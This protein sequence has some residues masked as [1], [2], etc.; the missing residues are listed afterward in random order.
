MTKQM[1]RHW[2]L[3][4]TLQNLPKKKNLDSKSSPLFQMFEPMIKVTEKYHEVTLKCDTVLM[5]TFL[6][7]AWRLML[8]T[9]FLVQNIFDVPKIQLKSHKPPASAPQ[10]SN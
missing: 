10:E 3:L 7:P 4:H 8:F 1:E 6:H 5:E 2:P 9:K